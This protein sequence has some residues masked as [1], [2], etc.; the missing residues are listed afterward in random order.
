MGQVAAHCCSMERSERAE[1]VSGRAAGAG[2]TSASTPCR[3]A[4]PAGAAAGVPAAAGAQAKA[5][6]EPVG[7]DSSAGGFVEAPA[8]GAAGPRLLKGAS[9]ESLDARSEGGDSTG[10]GVSSNASSCDGMTREQRKEAKALVKKFVKDM[11]KGRQLQ[12]IAP[13]GTVRAVFCALN[14]KLDALKI[15]ANK[16]AK[17]GQEIPLNTIDEIVAGESAAQ[18][19][20]CEGLET[21]LDE[22]SVTLVL[23]TGT[24]ITFR[25]DSLEARDTFTMCLTM[26]ANEHK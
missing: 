13:N 1:P 12:V 25:M 10:T 17:S 16:D 8:V 21:P 4:P 26:F 14:R 15:R 19:A 22:L 24:C 6:R 9:A 2:S 5:R 23:S 18:S 20:G 11:V 3:A 7:N